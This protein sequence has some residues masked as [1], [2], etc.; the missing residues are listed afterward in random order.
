[1]AAYTKANRTTCTVAK[2]AREQAR[3][4]Q[5]TL[6]LPQTIQ[7][8][9]FE[10]LGLKGPELSH[11]G[12]EKTMVPKSSRLVRART[13]TSSQVVRARILTSSHVVRA[14]TLTS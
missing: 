14:R 7:G 3:H 1:M 12:Y 10:V 4:K 9:L 5:E 8:S 11:Y 13:L 6:G 2:P